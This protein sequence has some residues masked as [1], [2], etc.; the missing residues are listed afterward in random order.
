M[1]R[2]LNFFYD[3]TE[4]IPL[5]HNILVKLFTYHTSELIPSQS[6]PDA[7]VV[8]DVLRATTTIATAL[9]IGAEAVATFKSLESLMAAS[10]NW[11]Q[12]LR[13]GE[14]GGS[15][16]PGCDLGNSPLDLSHELMKDKR[17]FISTTNGTKALEAVQQAAIVLT[18]AFINRQA[19][20]KYLLEKDPETVWLVGSG[21][22]GEYSL[23]DTA[24]AGAIAKSLLENGTVPVSVG[25]DEV[26]AAVALYTQWQDNILELLK[27][28]SHGQRLLRLDCL[29][30][31]KYCANLD[32][33]DTLPIQKSPGLL[34]KLPL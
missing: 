12:R 26:I 9:N 32:M 5:Y 33:V 22:E 4:V 1:T 7:A 11:P 13:A 3:E 10:E 15:K 6:L 30:D 29:A 23:E 16:V 31:L 20:V 28:A 14:R 18:G 25:N 17:L 21:W 24:C 8:I 2:F 19:V 34:V 27:Q